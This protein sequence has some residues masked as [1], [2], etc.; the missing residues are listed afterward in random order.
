MREFLNTPKSHFFA[1]NHIEWV[2]AESF[3]KA[4]EKLEKGNKKAVGIYRADTFTVY[5]VPVPET[6]HYEINRY[7]PQVEGVVLVGLF[8]HTPKK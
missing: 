5:H 7:T 4:V 6:S 2:T 3:L 1:T 8:T